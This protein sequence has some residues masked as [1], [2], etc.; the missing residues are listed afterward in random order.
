MTIPKNMAYTP[1][2]TKCPFQKIIDVFLN[3]NG[4]VELPKV[5][6]HDILLTPPQIPYHEIPLNEFLETKE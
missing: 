4:S 5:K 6:D 2:F 3:G 1:E